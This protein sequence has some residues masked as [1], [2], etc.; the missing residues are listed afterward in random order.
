MHRKCVYFA[1]K[2]VCA[3]YEYISLWT[4][5]LPALIFDFEYLNFSPFFHESFLAR[6][7]H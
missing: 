1:A 3:T 7:K 5:F 4:K 2:E 6:M